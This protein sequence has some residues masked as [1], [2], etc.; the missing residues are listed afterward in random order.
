LRNR[1]KKGRL[2][3]NKLPDA[4]DQK[5][6]NSKPAKSRSDGKWTFDWNLGTTAGGLTR[7]QFLF[8]KVFPPS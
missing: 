3:E 8:L 7:R 2:H 6:T 4:S 1:L 5:E